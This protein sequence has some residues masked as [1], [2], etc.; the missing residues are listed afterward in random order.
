MNFM[1]VSQVPTSFLSTSCSGPG[2][3]PSWARA[4]GA[5]RAAAKAA[6]Q[7]HRTVFIETLLG[8]RV[9][10]PGRLAPD[11]LPADAAVPGP[12]GGSPHDGRGAATATEREVVRVR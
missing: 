7:S 5:A 1:V 3:G 2:L 11:G 8:K 6:A 9:S 4:A 12:R 10:G